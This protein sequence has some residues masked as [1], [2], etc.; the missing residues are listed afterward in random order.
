MDSLIGRHLSYSAYPS[1]FAS[2]FPYRD[3]GIQ[4]RGR[5][6]TLSSILRVPLCGESF[7]GRL[8]S[9]ARFLVGEIALSSNEFLSRLSSARIDIRYHALIHK[10]AGH[11]HAQ[12]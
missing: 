2:I 7:A 10:I 9:T 5:R 3:S 11:T 8:L 1:D 4:R 6:G 12:T